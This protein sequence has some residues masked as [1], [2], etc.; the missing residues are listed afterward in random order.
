MSNDDQTLLTEFQVKVARLFFSLPAS[1]GFLLAGGGALLA[2]GLTARPTR[3]LDFFTRPGAG[4]VREARDEF[5]VAAEQCGWK[6]G[7]G[8]DGPTYCR[9]IV[10][11][12]EDPVPLELDLALDS[13]P[14]QQ[15]SVSTVGPTFAAAEQQTV[16]SSTCSRSASSSARACCSNW[17]IKPTRVSISRSS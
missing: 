10:G 5:A 7:L 2:H 11:R 9:V 13:G 8:R 12:D 6:V 16:I 1:E 4:D 17:R 15:P 3:D 14:I